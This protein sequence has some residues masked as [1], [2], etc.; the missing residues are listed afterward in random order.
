MDIKCS[1]KMNT[2]VKLKNDDK[3]G[4]R[5]ECYY[6][7]FK[8]RF[9]EVHNTVCLNCEDHGINLKKKKNNKWNTIRKNKRNPKRKTKKNFFNPLFF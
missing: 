6:C 9:I 2:P 1:C 5:Y 7:K 3:D 4:E 8:W